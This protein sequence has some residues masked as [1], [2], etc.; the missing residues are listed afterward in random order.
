MFYFLSQINSF[1]KD[2]NNQTLPEELPYNLQDTC[3]SQKA[4]MNLKPKSFQLLQFM[5]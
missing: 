3:H 1:D 2:P 4:E 5:V